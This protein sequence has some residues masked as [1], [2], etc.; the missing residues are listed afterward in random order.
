MIR[1]CQTL[2]THS[3][4]TLSPVCRRDRIVGHL[5]RRLLVDPPGERHRFPRLPLV[6][7]DVGDVREIIENVGNCYLVERDPAAIAEKVGL[8]LASNTRAEWDRSKSKIDAAW[9]ADRVLE[10]YDSVLNHKER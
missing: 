1:R 2:P 8:V 4:I 6:S 7:V 10:V 5:R 3:S 9:A